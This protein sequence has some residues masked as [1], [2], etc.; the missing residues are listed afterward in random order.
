MSSLEDNTLVQFKP[1]D[2]ETPRPEIKPAANASV[3][4]YGGIEELKNSANA[5]RQNYI[6][7]LRN[8]VFDIDNENGISSGGANYV[9]C[10]Y[11]VVN[12]DKK[13]PYACGGMKKF[14]DAYGTSDKYCVVNLDEY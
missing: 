10:L 5:M 3:S 9:A 8:T 4:S 2:N 12:E 6:T 1:T 7:R 13:N 14:K 11:D